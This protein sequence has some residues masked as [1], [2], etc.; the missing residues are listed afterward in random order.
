[1]FL[2]AGASKGAGYPLAS[3]LLPEVAKHIG[4]LQPGEVRNEWEHYSDFAS[5]TRG[6]SQR[7]LSSSNPEIVLTLLDLLAAAKATEMQDYWKSHSHFGK[8]SDRTDFERARERLENEPYEFSKA[9]TARLGLQ[10]ALDDFFW[11]KHTEDVETVARERR[12][13]LERELL[14]LRDG[15]VIVT[16]NWDTL[17]ERIL[18]SSGQW[19]PANGYGIDLQV[20]PQ[21]V[22]PA[23]EFLPQSAIRILKLHGSYGWYK[24]KTG[25]Y[26][27]AVRNLDFLPVCVG[28]SIVY[29]RDKNEPQEP[30]C[31][32]Y[33][34]SLMAYPS[35]IKKLVGAELVQI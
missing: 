35:F 33:P 30:W 10:R 29:L 19:N 12:A 20:A 14:P 28:D 18:G 8:T 1:L 24:G 15:D 7:I 13:Y 26:L 9:E 34:R 21:G 4:S 11:K 25:V 5:A 23:P 32:T 17:A 16:T 6:V 2:G 3:Q 27:S 22:A 31:K